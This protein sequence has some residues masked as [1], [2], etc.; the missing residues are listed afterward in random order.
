MMLCCI[1]SS[2]H[3]DIIM[4]MAHIFYI[5]IHDSFVEQSEISEK[6][7]SRPTHLIDYDAA[8]FVALLRRY[9]EYRLV[10]LS[11]PNGN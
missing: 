3:Y 9:T 8:I 1:I 5:V 4:V 6:Y 7:C 11:S 2:H 10:C